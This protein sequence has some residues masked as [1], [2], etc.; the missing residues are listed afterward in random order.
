MENE[1]VRD[2]EVNQ[3]FGW[4]TAIEKSHEKESSGAYKI[5]CQCR[6]GKTKHVA[7]SSLRAGRTLSCGCYKKQVNAQLKEQ[8]KNNFD[9]DKQYGLFK[10]VRRV[11]STEKFERQILA[12]CTGCGN[13]K[14]VLATNLRMGHS[15]TCGA[16]K[17]VAIFHEQ[18]PD[19][20]EHRKTVY[21]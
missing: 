15:R 14:V 19:A 18:F 10:P 1:I 16:R 6:C 20:P 17:C 3:A 8:H 4:L 11:A 7:A 9:M 5:K 13:T 2:I 21:N 12:E